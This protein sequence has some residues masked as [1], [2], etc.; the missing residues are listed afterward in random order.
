[1]P[2]H[3]SFA[4]FKAT[5]Q[6][7][8]GARAIPRIIPPSHTPNHTCDS[9]PLYQ[10]PGTA[11]SKKHIPICVFHLV[12][13]IVSFSPVGFEVGIDFSTGTIL[14]IFFFQGTKTQRE[15]YPGCGR[16]TRGV[17]RGRKTAETLSQAPP[18][19]RCCGTWG[20]LSSWKASGEW[21]VAETP[22]NLDRKMCEVPFGVFYW[23]PKSHIFSVFLV[24]LVVVS[25]SAT[26]SPT[27]SRSEGGPGELAGDLRLAQLQQEPSHKEKAT[28]LIIGEGVH[29]SSLGP[30]RGVVACLRWPQQY[31]P[32]R[33]T[34][35]HDLP[36]GPGLPLSKEYLAF[37]A[38]SSS[39]PVTYAATNSTRRQR[40]YQ[41]KPPVTIMLRRTAS[42]R[43]APLPRHPQSTNPNH[44]F[45]GS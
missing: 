41:R 10:P 15:K 9:Y 37:Y 11:T 23:P 38:P 21:P 13:N 5:K 32:E 14:Y 25:V 35:C 40:S 8:R 19:W 24:G 16:S 30:Y 29:R 22:T 28:F 31:P 43:I 4:A 27:F 2:A 7:F 6:E 12:K 20:P 42:T 26:K 44:Q 17:G 33:Q 3:G 45:E 18:S 34:G 1:M 36:A 39:R